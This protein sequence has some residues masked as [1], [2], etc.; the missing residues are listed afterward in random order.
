MAVISVA[1]ATWVSRV[2][3]ARPEPSGGFTSL[4]DVAIGLILVAH[5]QTDVA[6]DDVGGVR[7]VLANC[8]IQPCASVWPQRVLGVH[9]MLAGPLTV[10]PGALPG[11]RIRIPNRVVLLFQGDMVVS[12]DLQNPNSHTPT[13]LHTEVIWEL[14]DVRLRNVGQLA[15]PH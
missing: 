5:G 11:I 10:I 7:E 15:T 3:V 1:P 8:C 9:E 2:S 13:D 6:V 14:A 12:E 4:F